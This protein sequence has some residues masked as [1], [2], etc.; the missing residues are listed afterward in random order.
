MCKTIH[1]INF[2][3]PQLGYEELR[4]STKNY[5]ISFYIVLF[6]GFLTDKDSVIIIQYLT[7]IGMTD[8]GDTI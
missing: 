8:R 4:I 6:D 2:S 5:A 3:S 1:E 7:S